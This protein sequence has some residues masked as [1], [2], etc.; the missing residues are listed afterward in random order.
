MQS[1]NVFNAEEVRQVLWRLKGESADVHF[2]EINPDELTII[3]LEIAFRYFQGMVTQDDCC[4]HIESFPHSLMEKKKEAFFSGEITK[5]EY[6]ECFKKFFPK[7]RCAF[8]AWVGN[9]IAEGNGWKKMALKT[10]TTPK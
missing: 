8:A 10:K 1:V 4:R 6:E 7:S 5:D 9:R 2:E 3:D